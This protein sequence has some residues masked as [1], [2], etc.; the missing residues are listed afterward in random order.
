MRGITKIDGNLVFCEVN[1]AQRQSGCRPRGPTAV[2]VAIT[3]HQR[4]TGWPGPL[5]VVLAKATVG[6]SIKPH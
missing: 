2:D 3:E 6:I 4:R 1:T 5:I